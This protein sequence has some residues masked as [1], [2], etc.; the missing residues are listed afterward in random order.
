MLLGY[1]SKQ[2]SRIFVRNKFLQSRLRAVLCEKSPTTRRFFEFL[3][4]GADF[5]KMKPRADSLAS[6]RSMNLSE[7][8]KTGVSHKRLP[9]ATVIFGR[10]AVMSRLREVVDRISM[11][12]IPALIH[13][14]TGTGK[15][16]LANYIHQSSPWRNGPFV[17]VSCAAIPGTLLEAE[18]FG[19]EQGA[20][21][22]ARC[23]MPGMLELA[24][25]GTLLLDDV[26]AL[27]L[28]LQA[29]LLQFLQDGT[30]T[31][32]GGQDLRQV[33][34]RLICIASHPLELDLEKGL[35][36]E[37]LLHRIS[38]ITLH[39]PPLVERMD[40]LPGIADYLM[41]EFR[42][43]FSVPVATLTPPL[44]RRLVRHHWPGN[45]REL[46]NVLRRYALLGTPAAILEEL[47]QSSRALAQVFLMPVPVNSPLKAR[48]RQLVQQAEAHAILQ[49]LQE[50][51]W[52][53][54]RSARSLNISLRGL[55]YKMR[56]TGIHNYVSSRAAVS[57]EVNR[58]KRK[59]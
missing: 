44:I 32:L 31:R 3:G 30:F 35:F 15:E 27:D 38:G 10:S 8:A 6:Y 33:N 49:V 29:K 14:A 36:R 34:A 59:P 53:R 24:N 39:M 20:F 5:A 26:S 56:T 46:E 47:D 55:L 40:D 45:V 22:G 12:P 17:K 41:E 11:F 9:P 43:T 42:M 48:T 16:V 54:A 2:K 4:F 50:H 19:F 25:S 37:D 51:D 21:T 1:E 13:G 52:N 57:R 58:F 18:L 7:P 23:A 28:S